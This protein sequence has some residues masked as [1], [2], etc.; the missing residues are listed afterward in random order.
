MLSHERSC[1]PVISGIGYCRASASG[2]TRSACRASSLSR[3][4]HGVTRG[5]VGE[6]HKYQGNVH[7]SIV[8]STNPG[9]ALCVVRG[10]TPR[11]HRTGRATYEISP[12]WECGCPINRRRWS[13]PPFA[14]IEIS[15][16][17]IG[18]S[19]RP[20]LQEYL[21]LEISLEVY[22]SSRVSSLS[23]INSLLW[24]QLFAICLIG[25]ATMPRPNRIKR[26]DQAYALTA[27]Q[28]K[29]SSLLPSN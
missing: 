13:G 28:P 21:Q 19:D 27:R 22:L 2:N 26:G 6:R 16:T 7:P 20:R 14:P 9:R 8:V 1:E 5:P 4:G 12:G 10:A 18:A 29:R 15:F 25:V 11:S 23:G 17:L 3:S 24:L